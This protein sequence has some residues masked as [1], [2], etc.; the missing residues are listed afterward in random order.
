MTISTTDNVV[1]YAANGALTNFVFSFK[2][3]DEADIKVYISD[4]LQGSGYTVNLNADQDASPGGSIDLDTAPNAPGIVTIERDVSLVQETDYQPFDAFPAETHETALDRLVMITQQLSAT[5]SRAVKTAISSGAEYFL[6]TPVPNTVIGWDNAGNNLV[7]LTIGDGSFLVSGTLKLIPT[8]VSDIAFSVEGDVTATIPVGTRLAFSTPDVGVY[9]SGTV[10]L[11]AYDPPGNR[12]IFTMDMDIEPGTEVI[13]TWPVDLV[14]GTGS[15][16]IGT[17]DGTP[18]SVFPTVG[19]PMDWYSKDSL[20]NTRDAQISGSRIC[21]GSTL[22]PPS[23]SFTVEGLVD[24]QVGDTFFLVISAGTAGAIPVDVSAISFIG[25]D[26]T[27]AGLGFSYIV[28]DVVD[29]NYAIGEGALDS[30]LQGSGN[31]TQNIAVG[32]NALFSLDTGSNNL[33]IG[34]DS[35]TSVTSGSANVAMGTF[36][37][38]LSTGNSNT[39]VG[40]DAYRSSVSGDENTVVGYKA[41]EFING[42]TGITAVGTRA[43]NASTAGS[44]STA[45]G[46]EA[47][48]NTTG[49]RLV[50][51]GQQ[52]LEGSVG[53]AGNDNV[54]VGVSAGGD[55][56]DG[57]ENTL[58]GNFAGDSISNGE[59]NVAV[60]YQALSIMSAGTYNTAVGH[61]AL[62]ISPSS[63][64][65]NTAVGA[66]A[67]EALAG[68]EWNIAVGGETGPHLTSGF[69]NT[70]VG[71]QAGRGITSGENNI[72]IGHMA[73]PA[74]GTGPFSNKL[75][76]DVIGTSSPLIGGDFIDNTVVIN[77][78]L[79]IAGADAQT[80]VSATA[81]GASATVNITAKGMI[82]FRSRGGTG[83]PFASVSLECLVDGVWSTVSFSNGSNWV[84]GNTVLST[85]SNLR[86][87]ETASQTGGSYAYEVF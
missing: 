1:S 68:G 13:E 26:P 9:S 28:D 41:A 65:F 33:G 72:C 48:Q 44:N 86:V 49:V 53:S 84:G 50:A 63:A 66:G 83:S 30:Y 77:G 67:L 31:G 18:P 64:G 36:A 61:R 29:W 81:I 3:L 76:I 8:Y 74:P 52:A 34:V 54:A 24:T 75:F 11:A 60:G 5:L 32:N 19:E 14:A 56:N 12:S 21:T 46:S 35:L 37:A 58:V 45:V 43:L 85:G 22:G 39:V 47:C 62:R 16:T 59:F 80:T 23:R 82:N 55:I 57:N 4:V 7:N 69:R 6:P 40:V 51:V 79:N 42:Q 15:T 70:F 25:V 27:L 78:N 87:R 73:G 20:G 17:S 10:T 71:Y 38:R 2:V